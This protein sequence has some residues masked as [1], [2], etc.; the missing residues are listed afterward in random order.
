MIASISDASWAGRVAGRT[1][2]ICAW[3]SPGLKVGPGLLVFSDGQQPPGT[4]APGRYPPGGARAPQPAR[5]L[6]A[7]FDVAALPRKKVPRLRLQFLAHSVPHRGKCVL[8]QGPSGHPGSPFPMSGLCSISVPS[9]SAPKA[10]KKK[11]LYNCRF[12][13]DGIRETL[14]LNDQATL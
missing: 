11:G 2:V 12:L 1:L 7:A 3:R 13:K 14:E 9:I 4:D 5:P 10:K 6:P 8:L